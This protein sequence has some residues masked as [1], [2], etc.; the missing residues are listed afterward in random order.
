[1]EI[2]IATNNE[3]KVKEYQEILNPFGF[4][5]KTLKDLNIVCD[6]NETGTTFK[7]NAYIK[8]CEI[9]KLTDKIVIADDSGLVVDAYPDLLGVYSH[10]FLQDQ[11]YSVKN[12]E[13]IKMVEGKIRT[14]R[15]VCVICIMNLTTNPVFFEGILEGEIA[16]SI[17]GDNGFGYDP[18]FIPCGY[19]KAIGELG[20]EEK[21]KISHRGIASRKLVD[22]LN[23]MK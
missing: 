7:E 4:Q 12:A 17:K 1:M 10:R 13:L 21:H 3:D 16:T 15:Y 6:P 5:C 2:L 8:A 20:N 9:A 22:Y 23:K 11:P 19:S 18:I 14:G